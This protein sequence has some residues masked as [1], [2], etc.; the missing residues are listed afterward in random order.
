MRYWG[1]EPG[2]F[3]LLAEWVSPEAAQAFLTGP[4]HKAF[5]AAMDAFGS[6][7]GDRIVGDRID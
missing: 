5:G 4:D 1:A 6:V 3:I 7:V 2:E